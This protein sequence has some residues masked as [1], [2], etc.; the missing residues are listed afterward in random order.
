V[1]LVSLAEGRIPF[2]LWQQLRANHDGFLFSSQS[3]WLSRSQQYNHIEIRDN[4][5][6]T[7]QTDPGSAQP[8]CRLTHP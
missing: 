6:H 8:Y 4:S 5:M 2:R 1:S 3:S 7:E